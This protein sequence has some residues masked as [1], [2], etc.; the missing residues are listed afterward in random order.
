V[1]ITIT[2]DYALSRLKLSLTLTLLVIATSSLPKVHAADATQKT[3]PAP[4]TGSVSKDQNVH[5]ARRHVNFTP[6]E[7]TPVGKHSSNTFSDISQSMPAAAVREDLRRKHE[8]P[9]AQTAILRPGAPAGAPMGATAGSAPSNSAA[10][11]GSSPEILSPGKVAIPETHG[12]TDNAF[13]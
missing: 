7:G 8:L 5:A 6:A 3:A 10:A 1:V 4:L 12:S 13:R 9:S 2:W 11:T